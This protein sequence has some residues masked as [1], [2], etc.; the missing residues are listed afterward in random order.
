METDWWRTFFD[1]DYVRVW[2]SFLPDAASEEQADAI[3][4]TLRLDKGARVLDAPCGYGRLSRPLAVR[5]ARV[6][7]VDQSRALLEE[8]ERMRGG[9][10]EDRLRYRHHDLREPLPEAGFDAALNVFT[11][12][13]YGTEADDLAVLRTLASAVRPG[14]AVLLE[15]NHRD[16]V[17]AWLASGAP[18][19]GRRLEDG[20]LVVEEPR[21]DPLTGRVITGWYWQGPRGG[22]HKTATMRLYTVTELVRLVERA[23]LRLRAV[24]DT[25]TWAPVDTATSVLKAR[26]AVVA[27]RD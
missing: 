5:G 7:G 11:S 3:W 1:A 26:V 19:N 21:F 6:V 25:A 13:G 24:L 8:A 22:G 2:S 9:L 12:I 20:T 17:V 14:G 27:E 16:A 18:G 10:D 15:T 4:R 23:G